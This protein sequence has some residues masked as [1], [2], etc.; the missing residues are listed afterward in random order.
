[1]RHLHLPI[2]H[3]IGL[4]SYHRA[5]ATLAR[6][7]GYSI[8][9]QH[10]IAT[11]EV[12]QKVNMQARSLERLRHLRSCR[13]HARTRVDLTS[14][15]DDMIFRVE[16][17]NSNS[18]QRGIRKHVHRCEIIERRRKGGRGQVQRC[19]TVAAAWC[20]SVDASSTFNRDSLALEQITKCAKVIRRQ[21]ALLYVEYAYGI[22]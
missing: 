14:P 7:A 20:A 11:G 10:G 6:P 2:Q 5:V 9:S 16:D 15:L 12:W 22:L 21:L 13:S 17:I 1:M 19:I 4:T 8:V 3:P 18:L